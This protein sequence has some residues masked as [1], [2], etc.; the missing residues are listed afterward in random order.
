MTQLL[1]LSGSERVLEIGT[2][3][4]YQAAVLSHL[5]R[6]VY[7]FER[8]PDLAEQAAAVLRRLDRNNV[9]VH[10]GDGT[11]GLPEFAPYQAIIV[12]AAAPE[13]PPA[14]LHQLAEGGRL[15]IPVG[16][17]AGQY[18]EQWWRQ[19]G[20]F[21][22]ENLIPVAFVPLLGKQGWKSEGWDDYI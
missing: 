6:E 15:V 20:E 9:F 7:T 12:T 3:S 1:N 5:A 22:R 13:A 2:G 4:G 10:T 11:L 21:Q 16:G 18:L 17:K 19:G 8:H 14:L